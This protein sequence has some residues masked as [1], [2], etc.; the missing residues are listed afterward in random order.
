LPEKV[1]ADFQGLFDELVGLRDSFGWGSRVPTIRSYGFEETPRLYPFRDIIVPTPAGAEEVK[2]GQATLVTR[3]YSGVFG[4]WFHRA[5]WDEIAP[6][7]QP[8]KLGWRSLVLVIRWPA[9]W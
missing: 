3:S 8:V 4:S 5:G 6:R 7:V 9:R 1:R 2:S